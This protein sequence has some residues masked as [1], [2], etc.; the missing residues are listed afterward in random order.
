MLTNLTCV[1]QLKSSSL[2]LTTKFDLLYFSITKACGENIKFWKYL[3]SKI[4]DGN[5]VMK[6]YFLVLLFMP[7]SDVVFRPNRGVV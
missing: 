2:I 4:C 7:T 1:K 3:R 6:N 5:L